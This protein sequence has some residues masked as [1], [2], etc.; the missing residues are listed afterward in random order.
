MFVKIIEKCDEKGCKCMFISKKLL[1]L[2]VFAL[3]GAIS[4]ACMGL[5]NYWLT[6]SG[7]DNRYVWP[8]VLITIS[9]LSLAALGLIVYFGKISFRNSLV[10]IHARLRQLGYQ[11]ASSSQS[12]SDI[13]EIATAFGEAMDGMKEE[14]QS[15]QHKIQY[16]NGSVEILVAG[17]HQVLADQNNLITFNSAVETACVERNGF[18][19]IPDEIAL[20]A[21]RT[22]Q[23][24]CDI[25]GISHQ[26]L[27][28]VNDAASELE[29]M[30][31]RFNTKSQ[32]GVPGAAAEDV[33]HKQ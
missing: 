11:S 30:H 18:S 25:H 7:E 23:L 32:A 19:V 5:I 26:I 10:E 16:I 29:R 13:G 27:E 24:T 9:V 3:A 15:V 22:M 6:Q 21:D 12:D 8:M 1:L 31:T 20:L 33:I 2:I 17:L 28:V 14:V 4:A